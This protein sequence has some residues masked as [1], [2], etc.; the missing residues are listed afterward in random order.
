MEKPERYLR[1][2]QSLPIVNQKYTVQV[3]DEYVM[4]GNTAVLKCQVPSYMSEFVMVT[5]WVQ[6]TGMHLYP[7]T[8]IGGK[9]TVLANGELYINNAGTNDAYKSYTCRTVNRLTDYLKIEKATGNHSGETKEQTDETDQESRQ[10]GVKFQPLTCDS[11][12][13]RTR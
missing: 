1:S 4:T 10:L 12:A 11:G 6:D 2:E 9:Y 8:D 5:A 7:N 13:E 3:H